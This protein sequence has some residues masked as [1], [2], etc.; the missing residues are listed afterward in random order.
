MSEGRE[1]EQLDTC[2]LVTAAIGIEVLFFQM[3]PSAKKGML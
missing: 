1:R 2:F 3:L